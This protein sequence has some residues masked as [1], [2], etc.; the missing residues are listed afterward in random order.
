[1]THLLHSLLLPNIQ[2]AV[3]VR[4]ARGVFASAEVQIGHTNFRTIGI[5]RAVICC[6]G[7][8]ETVPLA[9]EPA[10]PIMSAQNAKL[11]LKIKAYKMSTQT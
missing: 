9:A 1:M 2:I 3:S 7:T 6:Q 10:V 4:C 8:A 11:T 5:T